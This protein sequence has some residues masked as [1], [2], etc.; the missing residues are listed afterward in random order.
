MNLLVVSQFEIPA[1]IILNHI[2]IE[3]IRIHT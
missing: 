3:H 2:S 1:I